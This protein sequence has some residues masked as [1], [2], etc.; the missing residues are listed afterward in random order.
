MAHEAAAGRRPCDVELR[1]PRQAERSLP[2]LLARHSLDHHTLRRV[3]R[4]HRR[5]NQAEL[6]T[7]C[8]DAAGWVGDELLVAS[9]WGA[10]L[11]R[12]VETAARRLLRER[13]RLALQPRLRREV[14]VDSEDLAVRL[15]SNGE[16]L[17]TPKRLISNET[18]RWPYHQLVVLREGGLH[19]GERAPVRAEHE[20]RLHHGPEYELALGFVERQ[21]G[22]GCGAG[23][24]R[25]RLDHVRAV[26]TARIRGTGNECTLTSQVDTHKSS[27]QVMNAL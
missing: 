17:T 23:Q 15:R 19:G 27:G 8:P 13:G 18:A 3:P 4:A 21:A 5:L 10:L 26:S 12:D 2:R 25:R 14:L 1:V 16:C 9:A 7:G 22:L 11:Q 6:A 24:S 20:G